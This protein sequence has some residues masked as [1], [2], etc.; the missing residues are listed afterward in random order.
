MP[1]AQAV[2]VPDAG[3]SEVDLSKAQDPSDMN[4][5]ADVSDI[6]IDNVVEEKETEEEA[7]VN[8]KMQRSPDLSEFTIQALEVM[9]QVIS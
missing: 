6:Q 4:I 7:A 8:G 1:Q 5:L 9:S 3:E 2:P